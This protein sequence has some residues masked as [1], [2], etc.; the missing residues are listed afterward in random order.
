MG[1]HP[2]FDELYIVSDLHLGGETPQRQ[3]FKQGDVFAEFIDQLLTLPKKKT[4]KQALVINGDLVDFLAEPDPKY[5]DLINATNKLDRIFRDPSFVSVWEALGKF[6]AS[7]PHRTLIITLGNHDLELALPRLRTQL[8][9]E[10]S[11]GKSEYR[12]RIRL[13]FEKGGFE[14][15]VG[16]AKVLC[17]HGNEVDPWNATDYE[18]LRRMGSDNSFS[19]PWTPNGGTKLVID[20]M[21]EIKAEYPFVDLLKPEEGGVIPT[22]LVLKPSLAPR[23]GDAVPSWLRSRYDQLRIATGF[24]SD[25]LVS[26]ELQRV[27]ALGSS[28][29]ILDRMLGDT[30]GSGIPLVQGENS[31]DE[32]LG[33]AEERLRQGIT[34]MQ[35]ASRTGQSEYLGTIGAIWNLVTFKGRSEVLREALEKLQKDRSFQILTADDTYRALDQKISE[36]TDFVTAGHTHLQRAIPRTNGHGFYYNSG[37]WVRLIQITNSMLSSTASF[38]P[39]FESLQHGSM[40]VLDS[41]P[42]LVK[43]VPTAVYIGATDKGVYGELKVMASGELESVDRSG[44]MRT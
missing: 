18:T 11:N 10:L 27:E 34:P 17:V 35:L 24:L 44:H 38:Q 13:E 5:F 40:M 37:T 9:H 12:D 20:V 36:S 19:G 16:D 28:T 4:I 30:F 33:R 26:A 29:K 42:D 43:L 15:Q 7:S 41:H 1:D 3:I 39:V 6:V 23:I 32:L 21:N 14:C 8:I 2:V 25:E 31:V 22:L